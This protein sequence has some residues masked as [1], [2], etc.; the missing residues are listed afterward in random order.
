MT[1]FITLGEP[2]VVFCSTQA[3]CSIEKEYGVIQNDVVKV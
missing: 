1:E 2:L 3:D